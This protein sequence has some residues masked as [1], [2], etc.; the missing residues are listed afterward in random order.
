MKRCGALDGLGGGLGTRGP[1]A[2]NAG[3]DWLRGGGMGRSDIDQGVLSGSRA[4]HV[5]AFRIVET[6]GLF[7]PI[8]GIIDADAFGAGAP[9]RRP[10]GQEK[11]RAAKIHAI[12]FAPDPERLTELAGTI[13]QLSR[14]RRQL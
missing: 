2:V 10:L 4:R 6:P 14:G 9:N 5:P 12:T 13:G 8:A 3:R 1:E 11:R 7:G